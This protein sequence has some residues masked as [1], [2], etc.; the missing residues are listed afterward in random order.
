MASGVADVVARDLDQAEL[1][2]ALEEPGTSA[3]GEETV[4]SGKT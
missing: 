3:K 2:K 1:E 4:M